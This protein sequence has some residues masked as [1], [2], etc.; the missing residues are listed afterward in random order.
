LYYGVLA[1]RIIKNLLKPSERR[2]TREQLIGLAL[3]L[4]A[5]RVAGWSDAEEILSKEAV[6][7]TPLQ[8]QIVF[9]IPPK[10]DSKIAGSHILLAH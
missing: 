7:P 4:G 6:A 5:R 8:L 3:Q 10:S 9:P 1:G 2:L